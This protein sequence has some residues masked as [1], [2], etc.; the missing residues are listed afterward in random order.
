LEVDHF[1]SIKFS[2]KA[3]RISTLDPETKGFPALTQDIFMQRTLAEGEGSVQLTPPCTNQFG[4]A[5]FYN[6]NVIYP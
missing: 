2:L 3:F 5:A 6:E 1:P 4:S